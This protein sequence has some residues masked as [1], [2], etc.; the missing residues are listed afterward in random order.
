[1]NKLQS[2]LF[3]ISQS[4]ATVGESLHNTSD[5]SPVQQPTLKAQP[6]WPDLIL[7]PIVSETVVKSKKNIKDLAV[8]YNIYGAGLGSFAKNPSGFLLPILRSQ[9]DADG[10]YDQ[11]LM[12]ENC[13]DSDE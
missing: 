13:H 3:S 5:E 10:P 6:D 2:T 1:M 4:L 8:L 7:L 12:C 9:I 11:C